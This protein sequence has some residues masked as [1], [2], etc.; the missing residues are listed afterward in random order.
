MATI[1]NQRK[2]AIVP[3]EL[4]EQT[5]NS[6][7]QNTFVPGITKWYIT[8]VSEEVEGSVTKKLSH[9]FIRTE[10]R[11]LGASPELDE[12][13]LNPQA[14]TLPGTVLGTSRNFN[15]ENRE[16]TGDCSQ[17]D[18]HLEVELSSRKT[19][20]STDSDPEVYYHRHKTELGKK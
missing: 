14:R 3:R 15:S 18:A 1:R 20:N 8:Q 2:L 7:S 6:Q 16:P 4:Q 13:L 19:S 5:T 11:I 17:N 12:V 9:K 10:L